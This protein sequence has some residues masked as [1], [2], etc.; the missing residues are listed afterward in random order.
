LWELFLVLALCIADLELDYTFALS[1]LVAHAHVV[2]FGPTVTIDA[3]S[4][5]ETARCELC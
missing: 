1:Y 5:I 2:G 3:Y 4:Y